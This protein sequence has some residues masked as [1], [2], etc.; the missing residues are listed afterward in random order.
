MKGKLKENVFE[1]TG[2]TKYKQ[3]LPEE[4][5]FAADAREEEDFDAD[6]HH[7]K[8]VAFAADTHHFDQEAEHDSDADTSYSAAGHSHT[9]E[10]DPGV[11]V[12]WF[13]KAPETKHKNQVS[14]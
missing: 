1:V 2:K 8:E 4:P 6:M 12:G 10:K 9:T 13:A 11:E 5:K 7:L 3:F 14:Y